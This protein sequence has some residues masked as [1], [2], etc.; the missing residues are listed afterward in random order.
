MGGIEAY[1]YQPVSQILSGRLRPLYAGP[2]GGVW[3][4]SDE[5]AAHWQDG[6]VVQTVPALP[7]SFVGVD[8]AGNVWAATESDIQAWNGSEW[9]VY[10]PESGWTQPSGNP[11]YVY[12]SVTDALGRFWVPTNADMRLF[13]G[14]QWTIF[15]PEDMG[16]ENILADTLWFAFTLLPAD[17]GELWLGV[18]HVVPQGGNGGQG[19]RVFRDGVWVSEDG[20]PA[21]GCVSALSGDPEGTL[22]LNANA[23]VWRRAN[24]A[25]DWEQFAPP[26]PE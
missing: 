23:E 11:A 16:L 1:A 4:V 13:D 5:A 19:V 12:R 14:E 20:L 21:D 3:L 15:T 10:G 2:D 7:G 26:P 17:S 18:C 9:M 22:W 25:G 8:L 6:R 24:P